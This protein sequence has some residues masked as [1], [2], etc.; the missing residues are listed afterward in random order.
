MKAFTKKVKQYVLDQG[1]DL[2]GIAATAKLD[3]LTPAGYNR[4]KDLLPECRST[5]VM[6][7]QWNHAL[8]DGLP[9][10]RPMYSRMMIMM[11]NF[12][13]TAILKISRFLQ[14]SGYLS[15]PE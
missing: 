10:L 13:D 14:D 3:E 11:N 2:V 7:M 12:I 8:V 9:E 5:L 6:A 1:L 4:P 15:L